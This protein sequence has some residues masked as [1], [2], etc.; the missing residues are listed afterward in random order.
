MWPKKKSC[1]V[2]ETKACQLPTRQS[3]AQKQALAPFLLALC[4]NAIEESATQ[5]PIRHAARAE[6]GTKAPCQRLRSPETS[7]TGSST[8]TGRSGVARGWGEA[9]GWGLTAAE[10]GFLFEWCNIPEIREEWRLQNLMIALKTTKLY[11]LKWW[12]LWYVNYNLNFS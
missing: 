3:I 1:L 9:R 12:L 11:T 7:T 5:S 10:R 2:R 4:L 6:Y 8:E